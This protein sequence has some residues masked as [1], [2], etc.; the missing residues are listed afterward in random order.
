MLEWK[1]ASLTALDQVLVRYGDVPGS[2]AA[3]V[4]SGYGLH[5]PEK[6]FVRLAYVDSTQ[7]VCD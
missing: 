7:S 4:R 1:G 6:P 5:P 3:V 2:E